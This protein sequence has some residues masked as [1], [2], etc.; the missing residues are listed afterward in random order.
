MI[1][2]LRTTSSRW[3]SAKLEHKPENGLKEAIDEAIESADALGEKLNTDAQKIAQTLE[4]QQP[5]IMARFF[6]T[7]TDTSDVTR[8]SRSL[9]TQLDA[10]DMEGRSR[11]TVLRKQNAQ[12]TAID[13][14][15]DD[16]AAKRKAA[17]D[18]EITDW[19]NPQLV[20]ERAERA[21]EIGTGGPAGTHGG[22]DVQARLAIL[23]NYVA[24]LG[25]ES[26]FIGLSQSQGKLKGDEAKAQAAHDAAELAAKAWAAL[27]SE[28]RCRG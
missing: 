5:G 14:A 8:R 16:L 11:L 20:T 22:P 27:N 19:A 6:G 25:R 26:D 23:T 2:R 13:A 15:T 12:Q 10:I 1:C 21:R 18:K 7:A 3:R 24:A 17:I 4:A 28:K 9:Q